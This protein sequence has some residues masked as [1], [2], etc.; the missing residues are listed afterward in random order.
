MTASILQT[1]T[2]THLA[3][4]RVMRV[5]QAIHMDPIST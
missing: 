4:M 3:Q 1:K 2:E 5:S